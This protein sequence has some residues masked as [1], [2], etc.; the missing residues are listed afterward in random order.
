METLQA[1]V[2]LWLHA[3]ILTEHLVSFLNDLPHLLHK[4]ISLQC[5]N[6]VIVHL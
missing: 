3:D 5:Q 1:L 4:R 6:K 2:T